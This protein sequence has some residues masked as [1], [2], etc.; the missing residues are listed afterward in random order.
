MKLFTRDETLFSFKCY[1]SAMLA[2]YISYSIGLSNPF[3]AMMTAYVVTTQPWAGSIRSKA[4][5]RLAGTVLG[6]GGAIAI[7]PNL[8]Q[9]PLLTTVAMSLW[10]GGCLYISL[11]DRTPR[12]YVF[13]LAGY[14]AALIGFPAV[15]DPIGLFDKGISRVEEISLGIMC[16]ALVH[17]LVLPRS[18]APVVIKGLDQTLAHARTWIVSTLRCAAPEQDRQNRRKLANDITQLRLTAT[19]IPFDTS[20]IRWSSHLLRALLNRIISLTPTISSVED[21]INALRSANR[22]L[23]GATLA[24]MKDISDW[25]ESGKQPDPGQLNAMHS[26]IDTLTPAIVP[27]MQWH[28]LLSASLATRLHELVNTY[29]KCLQMRVDLDAGIQNA[30]GE[31]ST[32]RRKSDLHID[33][34]IALQ[35][36]L[37]AAI[38]IGICCAFWI[39]TAWPQGSTAAMM[40]AVFSCFF[41]TL[42]NPAAPM[43]VFLRYTI[44]SIP[45]SAFYLLVALPSVH[46]FEML[47][48]VIFPVVFVLSALAIR[49]AYALKAMALLFGVLGTFAL[50]DVNQATLDIYL[51]SITGQLAGTAVAALVASLCRTISAERAVA[52]IQNANRQD[53]AALASTRRMRITPH[54]TSRMLDRVGLLQTRLPAENRKLQETP[55]PLLALRV[56]NDIAVLQSALRSVPRASHSVQR[57]LDYLA[58]F[59]RSPRK[60]PD[61]QLLRQLDDALTNLLLTPAIGPSQHRAVVA[62]VGLRRGLFPEMAPYPVNAH[63]EGADHDRRN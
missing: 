7:I 59:F 52:R 55:D 44:Y 17:T 14:T 19:H 50:M 5:Y 3:W 8:N 60:A 37:A 4:L 15:D 57:L 43:R 39:I 30:S 34:G 1:I 11:L 31:A 16:A 26:A 54:L 28:T 10:V 22:P 13:M 29:A 23:P 58:T 25:V 2:L 18:I 41:S 36:A 46:T 20:N 24:V 62:V 53:L 35:S 45:I 38:A 51:N 21:R 56:G 49:P 32:N 40:A 42:D 12:S 27:D 9:S 63:I 48:M 61:H 47:A 6:S 33:R